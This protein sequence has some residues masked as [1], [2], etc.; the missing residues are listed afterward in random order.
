MRLSDMNRSA[1]QC[2][3]ASSSLRWLLVVLLLGCFAVSAWAES[4]F[5]I[6]YDTLSKENLQFAQQ[7]GVTH[8][9][10]H[11]PSLGNEG[12]LDYFELLRMKKFIDSFGLE[13]LRP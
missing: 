13:P 6:T 7:M 12:V 1:G 11:S 5:K 8:I 4:A 2:K 3:S 10:V 9:V